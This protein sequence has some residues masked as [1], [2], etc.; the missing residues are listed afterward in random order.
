MFSAKAFLLTI[1]L[2]AYA[3]GAQLHYV[4]YYKVQSKTKHQAYRGYTIADNKVDIVVENMSSWSGDKYDAYKHE[5]VLYVVNSPPANSF[6]AIGNMLD[7]MK[8]VIRDN[9]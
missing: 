6:Y 7:D 1:I 2:A 9:V 3:L 4:L 5:G 8:K